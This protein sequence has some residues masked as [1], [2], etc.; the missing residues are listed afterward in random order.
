MSTNCELAPV[1]KVHAFWTGDAVTISASGT[2]PDP[3]SEVRIVESMLTIWPPEFAVQACS[4]A[5]FCIQP[6]TPYFTSQTFALGSRPDTVTVH[7]ADGTREVEVKDIPTL[8]ARIGSGGP[9]L[10]QGGTPSGDSY[11]EAVGLSKTFSMDEALQNALGSLPRWRPENPDDMLVVE[12]TAIEAW[13][14]GI[15]GFNDLAVRV[16]QPKRKA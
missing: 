2:L 7:V 16:R 5:P 8:T 4:T 9:G 15:A 11:D 6:V 3:C 1:D 14:G 13:F 12:V 10:A